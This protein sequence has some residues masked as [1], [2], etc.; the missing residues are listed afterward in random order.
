MCQFLEYLVLLIL[1]LLQEIE[2]VGELWYDDILIIAL[3]EFA[4]DGEFVGPLHRL[5]E[6]AAE[7]CQILLILTIESGHLCQ[8]LNLAHC[9]NIVELSDSISDH[10]TDGRIVRCL[11]LEESILLWRKPN[12]KSSCLVIHAFLINNTSCEYCFP[13]DAG[14][15]TFEGRTEFVR[16]KVQLAK[17][18]SILV[19]HYQGR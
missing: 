8:R 11:F 16:T 17:Q 6:V 3:S 4:A 7:P 10:C 12:P 14:K 13:A 9:T 15:M 18:L 1:D 2:K 19:Y 5:V